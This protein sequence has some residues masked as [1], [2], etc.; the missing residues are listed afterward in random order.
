MASICCSAISLDGFLDPPRASRARAGRS[1]G[2]RHPRQE[3]LVPLERAA[4]PGH[5]G[6]HQPARAS[7]SGRGLEMTNF[8]PGAAMRRRGRPP[9]F[10]AEASQ[11]RA[12]SAAERSLGPG[13]RQRRHLVGDPPRIA[14]R[15]SRQPAP[16]L[17]RGGRPSAMPTSRNRARGAL[18][19]R[20]NA[21]TSA[22]C[23]APRTCRW[24]AGSSFSRMSRGKS[25]VDVGP[26]PAM[27]AVEEAAEREPR[28]RTG[29]D[30]RE[31]G[32]GSRRFE[33]TELPAARGPAAS[34]ERRASRGPRTS[35]AQPPAPARAPPSAG[36]RRPAK[37]ELVDQLQLL[38]ESCPG[39]ALVS[40]AVRIPLR[41]GRGYTQPPAAR[42]QA[43]PVLREVPDSGSRGPS[44]RSNSRR[45][46]E[47]TGA[48]ETASRSCGKEFP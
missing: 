18:V 38:V 31:P 2:S 24:T 36:E 7:T 42:S 35:T 41:E 28:L 13:V 45:L 46:G 3:V 33:P 11:K 19:G 4:R 26:P 30:V 9:I 25:R 16:A 29:I 37:A 40:I 47:L 22:A 32:S 15:E 44:F 39:L 27:F 1:S 12:P 5:R 17:L 48:F 20:G 21:A 43:S 23:L 8:R 34:V 6:R 10:A 14:L